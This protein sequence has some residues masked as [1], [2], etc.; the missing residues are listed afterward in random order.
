MEAGWPNVY[1]RLSGPRKEEKFC[2]VLLTCVHLT[3]QRMSLWEGYIS[4]E[5]LQFK[6]DITQSSLKSVSFSYNLRESSTFVSY[7]VEAV[8]QM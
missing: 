1:H 6:P 4:G 5:T 7:K 2:A 3:Q 8:A